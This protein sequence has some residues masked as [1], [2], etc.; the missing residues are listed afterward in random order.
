M[1]A[2]I[3]FLE[4]PFRQTIISILYVRSLILIGLLRKISRYLK[5]GGIS[6]FKGQLFFL[7][8]LKSFPHFL[9]GQFS[10]LRHIQHLLRLGH[11]GVP[12]IPADFSSLF[13]RLQ[14]VVDFPVLHTR[15][16][17]VLRVICFPV[18]PDLPTG[19]L[20]L[21][22]CDVVAIAGVVPGG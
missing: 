18:G 7:K 22:W 8:R 20:C 13:S 9:V 6:I 3:V 21:S 11:N 1:R 15:R 2:W 19:A 17:Q 10:T 5:Y 4:P 14:S 12:L 16:T